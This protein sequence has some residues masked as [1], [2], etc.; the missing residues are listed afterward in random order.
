[1]HLTTGFAGETT[2]VGEPLPGPEGRLAAHAAAAQQQQAQAPS[3]MSVLTNS[4]AM[5]FGMG[6]MFAIARMLF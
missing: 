2:A 4:L 3:A 1:M 6:L 5:G